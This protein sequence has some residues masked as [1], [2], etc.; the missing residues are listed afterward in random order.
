MSYQTKHHA[1]YIGSDWFLCR[2]CSARKLAQL[3]FLLN[4]FY[5]IGSRL[6]PSQKQ[7]ESEQVEDYARRV[8]GIMARELGTKVT[9]FTSADKAEYIKRSYVYQPEGKCWLLGK[10][11]DRAKIIKKTGLKVAELSW[12]LG[13]RISRK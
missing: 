13:M 6:L 2:F 4:S 11:S 8:Q 12:L 3:F 9:P 5:E 1:V 7:E 10:P